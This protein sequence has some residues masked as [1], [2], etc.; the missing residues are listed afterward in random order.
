MEL[1]NY[2]AE[3]WGVSLVVVSLAILTKPKYLKKLFAEVENEATMFFWGM[4]SLVIGLAMVLAYNVWLQNWQVIITIL[5]WLSL[6]KGLAVLFF[7]EYT[8][9]Y[10]KKMENQQWLPIALVVLVFIGLVITYF[11]FTG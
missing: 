3:L 7:P 9:K 10:A 1:S 6:I 8:K 2:L 4:V 11:G 5:G